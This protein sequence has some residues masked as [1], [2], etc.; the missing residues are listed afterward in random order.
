MTHYLAI[1]YQRVLKINS[2]FH[3]LLNSKNN[4]YIL[5]L[6]DF[7]FRLSWLY[8]LTIGGALY[9]SFPKESD[10]LNYGVESY[11]FI[12]IFLKIKYYQL[13]F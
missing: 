5:I 8:A 2:P 7:F 6:L 4:D 1:F 13:I 10:R 11:I 3:I 9:F 12:I